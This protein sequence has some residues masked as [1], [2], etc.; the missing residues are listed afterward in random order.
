[1]TSTHRSFVGLL[2][3][4]LT[5]SLVG[6]GD[7][8]SPIDGGGDSA[9]RTDGAP[10]DSGG[11]DSGGRDS[12]PRRDAG[13]RDSGNADAGPPPPPT[14]CAYTSPTGDVVY[15]ATDGDD[16]SGDGGMGSPWATITHALDSVADG[17]TILVRPG[18]YTGR[19]RMRGT[20]PTGVTV[21]SEVPYM[22]RLRHS[23][24]VMTFYTDSRGC[25][26]ITVEGFDIAHS[27]AGA[28]ALVVQID[29]DGR[30]AVRRI[31]LRNNVLH[32][33]FNNDILKVNNGISEVT[34]ERNMFFNQTGQDEHIDIN[35]AS[36]VIVQDNIFFN[37]FEASRRTNA[38][39][40]SSYIVVKDSGGP[41]DI[42][43]G[44]E[45]IIIRR[46]VFLHYQGSTG[47][48][49]LLFGEDGKPFYEV[50]G[51]TV[52]NNLFVGD[53]AVLMRSPLGVK[54]CENILFRNNTVVGD[55]PSRAFAF[56]YNLEG[57]NLPIRGS[58]FYNNIWS[59]PT[60]TMGARDASDGNDFSDASPSAIADFVIDSNLYWNGGSAIPED[61]AE[62]INPSDDMNAI[63]ADPE[64]GAQAGLVVPHWD[65][66]AFAEG[67]SDICEAFERVVTDYGTPAAGSAGIDAADPTE[68]AADDILGRTRGGS[69]D[70]G[71]VELR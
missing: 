25:D 11:R 42:Y 44:S 62:A 4:L 31:T 55:L 24:T 2:A 35:S 39:D 34:I 3:L 23:D 49:F 19:I 10:G 59:D 60:G 36:G 43:T 20:F 51:A 22:A 27:G 66:S 47:T 29:A 17:A 64:L 57:E 33:S 65:G 30:G 40:T 38:N 50:S 70:M 69:P 68:A 48:G 56:R 12:G 14:A 28:G 7:D 54:G 67:S 6:C 26:G 71:A 53:S 8:S 45:N 37:D 41:S 61:A 32:D 21:R 9:T 15:V 1:M 13:P 5:L 63:T 18:T 16:G 52:E 46:N 58:E